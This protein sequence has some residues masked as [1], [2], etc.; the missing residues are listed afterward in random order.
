[1]IP[2]LHTGDGIRLFH[3]TLVE[4]LP[5][6]VQRPDN[7]TVAFVPTKRTVKMTDTPL[8][9]VIS[10][11]ATVSPFSLHR[12]RIDLFPRINGIHVDTDEFILVLNKFEEFSA[13][14]RGDTPYYCTICITR[15]ELSK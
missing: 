14:P 11:E 1:V 8:W 12:G 9:F 2:R 3:L 10:G 5:F 13:S 6:D 7:I 15:F 4:V